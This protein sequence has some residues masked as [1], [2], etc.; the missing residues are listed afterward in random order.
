[1]S[2]SRLRWSSTIHYSTVRTYGTLVPTVRRTIIIE[3]FVVGEKLCNAMEIRGDIISL[4]TNKCSS[5]HNL[6]FQRIKTKRLN[7]IYKL[8]GEK[9]SFELINVGLINK[10]MEISKPN[11]MI[12]GTSSFRK[13]LSISAS[14]VV[15]IEVVEILCA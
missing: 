3:A 11:I 5:R 8:Q 1:M 9:Y 7:V 12:D 4:R 14:V 2:G 6:T 15:V 10:I 13:F